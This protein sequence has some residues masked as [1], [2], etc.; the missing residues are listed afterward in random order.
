[1]VTKEDESTYKNNFRHFSAR[2][3]LR[4]GILITF[5]TYVTICKTSSLKSPEIRKRKDGKGNCLIGEI[6]IEGRTVRVV[7]SLL[8]KGKPLLTALHPLK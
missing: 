3:S 5:W 8:L 1:M 2:L 7:K 6:E 4:Y